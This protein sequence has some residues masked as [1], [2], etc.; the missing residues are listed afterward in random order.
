VQFSS[1]QWRREGQSVYFNLTS[2]KSE[3]KIQYKNLTVVRVQE[4]EITIL[5]QCRVT[6]EVRIGRMD[7]MEPSSQ[8][9]TMLHSLFISHLKSCLLVVQKEGHE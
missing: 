1:G 8:M 3:E 9:V 7:V 2:I 4:P 6:C 5:A